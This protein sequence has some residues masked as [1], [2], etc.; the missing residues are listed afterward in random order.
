MWVFEGIVSVAH[1]GSARMASARRDLARSA[2]RGRGQAPARSR[3]AA[4]Y[5]NWYYGPAIL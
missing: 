3:S 2:L 5:G 4:A 1:P